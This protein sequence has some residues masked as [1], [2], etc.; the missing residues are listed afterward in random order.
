MVPWVL[1][2]AVVGYGL[3]RVFVGHP[4]P[5]AGLGRLGRGEAAFVAAAADALYP[6][7]GAVPP[8]GCE[9]GIP[10]Y[11]DRYL[12]RVPPQ[13]RGLMRALFFLMQHA[14]LFFPAPGPTGFR[15][16]SSLDHDQRVAVLSGWATSR[17]FPRRFAF[18]SL[19]A[20]LTMGYFADPEVLRRLGLAP[21]AFETPVCEADLLYPPIGSPPEAIA[22][23]PED[24]S[25]PSAPPPP[26]DLDGPLHPDYREPAGARP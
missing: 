7:G 14:T 19:R 22:H 25:R 15:R 17:F 1:V 5:P 16:F 18:T 21:Y 6:P 23:R 11:V 20:V 9:A 3:V 2:G 4:T 10:G 24:V 12:D 26:L 8:S 13:T